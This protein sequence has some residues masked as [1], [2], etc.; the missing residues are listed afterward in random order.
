M[1][2]MLSLWPDKT[3]ALSPMDEADTG[4]IA[5][6]SRA[7]TQNSVNAGRVLG[8]LRLRKDR[9]SLEALKGQRFYIFPSD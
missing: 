1:S 4:A 2:M 5:L 3:E 9:P 6:S 7:I 8:T